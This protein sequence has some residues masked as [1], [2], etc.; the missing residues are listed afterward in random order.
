MTDKLRAAIYGKFPS[1]A[2]FANYLGWELPTYYWR[3]QN[4]GKMKLK[5][6]EQIIKALGLE[7]NPETLS[8]FSIEVRE[9][10]TKKGWR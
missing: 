3:M 9:K 10:R 1:Q 6:I 8:F 7:N 5:Q 2:A 4:P